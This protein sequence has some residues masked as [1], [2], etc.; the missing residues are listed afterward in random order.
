MR[1]PAHP[2]WP[3]AG[4]RT[5][6]E[7]VAREWA[8]AYHRW[9]E[10]EHRERV[11][12]G[13]PRPFGQAKVEYLAHRKVQVE[14][15]TWVNDRTALDHLS[16]DFA[17]HTPVE[18]LRPQRT[19]DRLLTQMQPLTVVT[20]S[21]CLSVFFG[22]LDLPYRVKLPR[23]ERPDVRVWTDD[24]VVAI[25]TAAERHGMLLAVDCGLYMG[26]RKGEIWGV[27]WPDVHERTV[28]VRRQHPGRPLKGKR[29]RSA[30]ILPGWTHERRE[31]GPV[32]DMAY[33]RTR[34][35]KDVLA[36]VGLDAERTAWH[37]LRHTYARMFLER[38]PDLRLLQASLGHSSVTTTEQLY[39]WLGDTAT[40]LAVEGIW[41]H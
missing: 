6:L 23:V 8:R 13:R 39:D 10:S 34:I 31:R 29:A 18:A 37:S 38:K 11:F 26:L 27:E 2:A 16:D 3:S 40:A 15:R 22:W 32:V 36:D 14:P 9:V 30:V 28:R 21:R 41:Q 7:D 17:A 20:Y 33:R 35:I 12:G 24:E 19:I 4:E 25:R 1:D 5:E